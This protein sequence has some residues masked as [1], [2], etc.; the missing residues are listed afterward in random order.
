MTTKRT[1]QPSSRMVEFFPERPPRKDMQNWI[2]IGV[3]GHLGALAWHLGNRDTTIVICE[4][5]L[6]WNLSQREGLLYPDLLV[7]FSADRAH[8]FARL[9]FAMDVQGKPPE[10]VLE[11]ASRTTAKN[12]FVSN[13]RGYADFG[14]PEYWRFY[15]SGSDFYPAQLAGDRLVGGEY[16]PITI[17]QVEEGKYRGHS[18]ALNLNLCWEHGQL[19]WFDPATQRYLLTHD[20]EADGRIAAEFQLDTERQARIAAEERV[21]QLE[22]EL[23]RHSR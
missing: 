22:E 7:A 11:V 21:R 2:H 9:G 10:F 18:D 15:P 17:V 1:A 12:D 20:D 3:P 23:R 5:A 8:V 4:P 6:G 19:H 14:V 13:R 16:Q